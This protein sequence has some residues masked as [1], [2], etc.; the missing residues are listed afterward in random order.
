MHNLQSCYEASRQ[1]MKEENLDIIKVL[2][3]LRLLL[4]SMRLQ[5]VVAG[6]H[7]LLPFLLMC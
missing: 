7:Y 4:R 2:I 6:R 5:I 1:Y 3:L